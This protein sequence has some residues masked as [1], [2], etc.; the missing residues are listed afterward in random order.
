MTRRVVELAGPAG[1][2]K[3]TLVTVL[4]SRDPEAILG[5]DVG[6][7]RLAAGL[8]SA[9]PMSVAARASAPG[10]WWT[11]AELRS[12][13]Y[14]RAWRGALADRD[15]DGLVLLDHGPVFRLAALAAYGPPMVHTTAFRRWWTSTARSWA[16][17]LDAVFWLDAPDEVLLGRV[18]GR[19]RRH[20]LRG[21]GQV[22]AGEFLDRYRDAYAE[23]LDHVAAAGTPVVRLDT[24]TDTRDALADA[25]ETSLA[26][27]VSRRSA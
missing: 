3:T 5:V 18:E 8:A 10:R 21:V 1:A 17:T 6:R 24:S 12:L 22:A 23:A 13:A 4:L 7:L 19:A 27:A 9:V 16:T 26:D 25:I 20:R 2:G 11:E 14:L 15:D